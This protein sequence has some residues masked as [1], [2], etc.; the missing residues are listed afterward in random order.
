MLI[1]NGA[2]DCLNMIGQAFLNPGDESI[3]R[4]PTVDAYRVATEF[5]DATP[6]YVPLK[7]DCIDLDRVPGAFLDQLPDSIVVVLD[8]VYWEISP[9]K[10][11]PG[12]SVIS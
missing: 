3:I 10:T 4:E 6:G 8:Q 7:D 5:M 12:S 1:G 9:G 2:E 11:R